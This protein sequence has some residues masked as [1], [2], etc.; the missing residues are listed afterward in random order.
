[1]HP[2][3]WWPQH[4][5]IAPPLDSAGNIWVANYF[6]GAVSEFF[7]SGVPVLGNW[8]FP[9]LGWGIPPASPS[10]PPATPGSRTTKPTIIPTAVSANSLHPGWNS[11]AMATPAA[12]TIPSP[13]PPIQPGPFGLQTMKASRRRCWTTPMARR[14]PGSSGYGYNVLPF[15]NAVA[16]DANHNA[17]FGS[18]DREAA[19]ITPSGA[20]SSFFP[21]PCLSGSSR[22]D[23]EGIAI[24]PSG[25][26]WLADKRSS[27]GHRAYPGGQH[28]KPDDNQQR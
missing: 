11:P 2:G 6:G 5:R 14:S 24:D 4:S 13:S 10:I 27:G 20:V 9:A 26:V 28:R 18:P 16:V 1:M 22:H 7:P 25:N 21:L 12:S 8:A 19:L 17:W 23:P 15:I 3:L